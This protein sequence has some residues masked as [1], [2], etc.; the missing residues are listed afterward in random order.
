MR[1]VMPLAKSNC[2]GQEIDMKAV[3]S[4]AI[5]AIFF[6]IAP[7]P[8]FALWEIAPVDT[9]QAKKMGI[10]IRS[11]GAGPNDVRIEMEFKPE[12]E[13]KNL[14]RVDLRLGGDSGVTAPLKEDRS[15]PG[16]VIVSFSASKAQLD[17]IDLWIM[18]P[19]SLG[20]VIYEIRIKDFVAGAKD[21]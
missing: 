6:A 2:F 3:V 10:E 9:E 18:V 8:C 15:K 7:R 13:L 21:K 20:G 11:I 14:D 16:R 19:E 4:V 17:K 12:G 1:R 5:V